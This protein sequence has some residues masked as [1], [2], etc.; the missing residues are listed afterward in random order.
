MPTQSRLSVAGTLRVPFAGGVDNANRLSTFVTPRQACLR[1]GF[2]LVELLVVITI[3]G[4][5]IALL[6][7][8]VQ[9]VREN[10][11]QTQCN[12][13]IKQIALA[14]VAHDSS[15]GQF[16]GMTQFVKRSNSEVANVIYDA[17]LRKFTV[18]GAASTTDPKTVA[19]LSWATILLPRLERNDIWDLI[20]QPGTSVPVPPIDTFVCPSDSDVKAQPDLGGLS[21]SANCG[22]WDRDKSGDFLLPP[23]GDTVDNGIFFDL[24]EYTRN[25]SKG[26]Q[27]RM[28]AIKDGSG[29]TI[30]FAE[31]IHKTYVSSANAPLFSWLAGS[32]RLSTFGGY[33]SEQQLGVVWVVP[34]KG[35]APSPGPN[36]PSGSA[37]DEQ[38]RIGGNQFDLVDFDPSKPRF[39]RPASRHGSGAI[40]AFCDGH[41]AFIRSD[42]DYV[43]YQQLL[44]P[45]GRK[46]VNPA[47]KT[48]NGPAMNGF[49][50]AAPLAEKDY[51]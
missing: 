14:A 41:S 51:L 11:R 23:N 22:G 39:A 24:A 29:T 1:R 19:G 47:D 34:S 9:A 16:P 21:Y 12:N 43:V 4:M 38:E 33:P 32:E 44:T 46:A 49:R 17:S 20:Q 27:M 10:A 18:I 50:T 37:I 6:L 2:T 5:L 42:I 25:K 7:P 30:M 26:P 3:I 28:S 45:N 40:V 36:S 31:N 8:A 48:D 15:R 13:N 35:T